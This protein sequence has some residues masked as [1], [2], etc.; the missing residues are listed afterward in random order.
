MKSV[1]V[2]YSLEGSTRAL[3]KK[4]A[5]EINGDILELNPVKEVNSKG[6]SKFVWGGMQAVMKKKPRLR[7]YNFK[8]N[9][10]ENVIIGTPVWAGT[11]A[12][13]IRTFLENEQI[14]G[15]KV[16]FFCCHEGGIGK[17]MENLENDLGLNNTIVGKIDLVGVAK[18][19]EGAER[20]L[21]QW[22]RG[23]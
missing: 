5:A 9:Q 21:V 20:K 22:Y 17:T 19:Y 1:I 7:E 23:L 3:A 18:D 13:P 2:F 6:F 12:P 8:V 15:K 10:Y 4:L 16:S 11:Y 14:V